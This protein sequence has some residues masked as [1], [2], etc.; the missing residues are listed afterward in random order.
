VAGELRGGGVKLPKIQGVRGMT[1]AAVR[2]AV[3][4]GAR[5]RAFPYC[6][7]WLIV[8]FRRI[9]DPVLVKPGEA[10]LRAGGTQVLH[11]L[12]FGWWGFP[13][14]PIWTVSTIWRTL[15]GG[16]DVTDAVMADLELAYRDRQLEPIS[17]K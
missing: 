8:S 11:S 5:F 7:S 1:I 10:M 9:S 15:H 3:S 13:W 17:T 16:I 12:L 14:G 6:E 4:G 2:S